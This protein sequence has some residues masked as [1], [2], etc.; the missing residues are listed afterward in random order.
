MKPIP[1][2]TAITVPLFIYICIYAMI[3]YY[4]C[5]AENKR[6]REREK[7]YPKAVREELDRLLMF[8]KL[9]ESEKSIS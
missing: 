4:E 8:D 6:L 9:D 2:L 7:K 1:L 3:I 5:K